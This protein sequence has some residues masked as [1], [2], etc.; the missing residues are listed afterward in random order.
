MQETVRQRMQE[1]SL[2]AEYYIHS[3]LQVSDYQKTKRSYLAFHSKLFDSCSE[4]ILDDESLTYQQ[5]LSNLHIFLQVR[6]Q[7]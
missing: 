2:A 5:V 3:H 7:L 1:W 4:S 6:H